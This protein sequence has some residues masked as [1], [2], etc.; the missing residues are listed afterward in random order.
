MIKY[1]H[2]FS[3]LTL[4]IF[5]AT[6]LLNHVLIL[7]S[8]AM[9]I[10]F[11]QKARKVYRHPV[12]EI[13]L[14]TAVMIQILSGLYLVTQKW[15][16]AES[17]F[18]WVQIGSG[19]YLSFFLIYHVR[20][21]LF[22]RYK[23]KVDTNLYYGVGVMHMFPQKLIY[24]PYYSLAILAFSFH[25]ACIHRIKMKEFIPLKKAEY[26][27]IEIMILGVM[28]TLLIILKMLQLKMPADFIGRVENNKRNELI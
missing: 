18:D 2:Y 13:I 4:G 12:V 11:M 23:L 20:A 17:W 25:V 27:A 21:V 28:L 8:E 26:E 16:K 22:G 24:I 5:L 1:I 14:L 10:S 6:H 3:G 15:A 9:H 19:L 7:H